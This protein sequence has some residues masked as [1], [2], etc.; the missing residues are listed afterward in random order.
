MAF[1]SE[2]S[3]SCHMYTYCDTWHGCIQSH[4][5]DRHPRPPV[6]FEPWTQGS[7]DLCASALAT[8][9]HGRLL[10]FGKTTLV[11]NLSN[12]MIMDWIWQYLFHDSGL[13]MIILTEWI[14]SIRG[15]SNSRGSFTLQ[16]NRLFKVNWSLIVPTGGR[17]THYRSCYRKKIMWSCNYM[18]HQSY[19]YNLLYDD[20]LNN[21][22]IW[23]P[24]KI[25]PTGRISIFC[26]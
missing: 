4:P 8:A 19:I 6:G 18:Y 21:R 16:Y 20:I 23:S 3:F 5:K 7:Q 15:I 10:S 11:W 25:V 13:N 12:I 26:P 24:V 22:N 2:G 1:S 17:T 14:K 9:P